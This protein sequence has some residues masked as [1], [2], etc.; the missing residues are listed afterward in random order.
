M[1]IRDRE[2]FEFVPRA[3]PVRRHA[4]HDKIHSVHISTGHAKDHTFGD[5]LMFPQ[6]LL[7]MC[8]RDS[9]LSAETG[10]MT[11]ARVIGTALATGWAAGTAAAF[12][13]ANRPLDEAVTLIR[14]Q[15]G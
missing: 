12:H 11:S 6:R 5:G 4:R 2:L 10:A 15:M 14:K 9:C 3:G 7:K 8:I 13:A 1:C